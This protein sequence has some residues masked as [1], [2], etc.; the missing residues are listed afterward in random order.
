MPYKRRMKGRPMRKGKYKGKYKGKKR[1][2]YKA[3]ATQMTLHRLPGIPDAITVKLNYVERFELTVALGGAQ[4]TFI[5]SGNSVFSPRVTAVGGNPHK[6]LY[7]E[8]YAQQ[9][10]RYRVYA[11][12]IRMD[13]VN[14][15]SIT[16]AQVCIVP[17][18][19]LSSITDLT[20][21][22]E[23]QRSKPSMMIPVDTIRPVR[24][25]DYCTTRKAGGLS[26]IESL[27]DIW[28]APIGSNPNQQ[29]YWNIV[30]ETTT[31]LGNLS[32]ICLMKITY[33]VRF[34]ERISEPQST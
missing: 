4:Q 28:S 2:T 24:F 17:T 13:C 34:Y 12:S 19:E 27:E 30:G 32:V 26:K 31:G 29:W 20:W 33:Y 7:Y 9:Y 8:W 21:A 1:G 25:K 11:S 14:N 23:T 10:T 3:A 6:P 15:D 18:D 5:Y 22:D 16:A